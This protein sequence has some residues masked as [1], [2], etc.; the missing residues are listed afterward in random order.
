[1]GFVNRFFQ[2]SLTN[3]TVD[4][5]TL[6]TQ[7]LNL[8]QLNN[9]IGLHKW[10]LQE[11]V[12]ISACKLRICKHEENSIALWFCFFFPF[13]FCVCMCLFDCFVFV[14]PFFL[15]AS[16]TASQKKHFQQEVESKPR[17]FT[18]DL[19]QSFICNYS[20]VIWFGN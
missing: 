15:I 17:L 7:M 18:A 19:H 16:F 14:S 20:H 8:T 11:R 6:Q 13:G 9:S 2:S 4:F 10:C 3:H 5:L 1:M 12:L